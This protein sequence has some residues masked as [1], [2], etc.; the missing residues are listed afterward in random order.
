MYH[1]LVKKTP[2]TL[3]IT[4][5]VVF[6]MF[7]TFSGI[8]FAANDFEFSN[9]RVVNLID[10][11][12]TNIEPG[13]RIQFSVD[14]KNNQEI[15]KEFAYVLTTDNLQNHATWITSLASPGQPFSLSVSHK[16]DLEGS[17]QVTAYLTNIPID[18]LDQNNPTDY[19]PFD[20]SENHLADPISLTVIVSGTKKESSSSSS[21]SSSSTVDDVQEPAAEKLPYFIK[22]TAELWSFGI[23]DDSEFSIIIEYLISEN[24][25]SI[26]DLS[27][28]SSE[29][30]GI[31]TWVRNIAAWWVDGSISE[32]NFVNVLKYLVE[33]GIIR[34]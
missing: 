11:P 23:L 14:I 29:T 20:K 31:P 32:E 25:I 18:V 1:S 3:M 19:S 2:T 8:V 9:L 5:F 22:D 26:P 16:F 10:E 30:V 15:Q 12:I 34:V 7:S 4:C 13:E 21:S 28:Q 33:E 27:E 24:I 17:Y 6:L